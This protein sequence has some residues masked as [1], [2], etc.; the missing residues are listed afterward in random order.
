MNKCVVNT[1]CDNTCVVS[2]E[3]YNNPT[4]VYLEKNVNAA[5]C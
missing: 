1:L 5:R 4:G 2:Y 3:L